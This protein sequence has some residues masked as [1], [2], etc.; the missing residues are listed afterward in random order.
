MKSILKKSVLALVLVVFSL[1]FTSCQKDSD[2]QEGSKNKIDISNNSN[3]SKDGIPDDKG[4]NNGGNNNGGNN[5]GGNNNGGNNNGGNN[6]GGNSNGGNNNQTQTPTISLAQKM[7][8]VNNIIGDDHTIYV[9]PYIDKYN[10]I[11]YR[12]YNI[13]YNK[14]RGFVKGNVSHALY[15]FGKLTKYKYRNYFLMFVTNK[16]TY[17]NA[18]EDRGI[19]DINDS[20]D[21]HRDT[22]L[23]VFMK[24]DTKRPVKIISL[25]DSEL[26]SELN[27][28]Y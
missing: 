26:D 18:F 2:K 6:N 19:F 9:Y 25:S 5:N 1:T 8:E 16:N 13:V 20:K 21:K 15:K 14:K 28:E 11:F 24:I 12:E 23:E 17:L 4:N 7:E 10:G 22:I 3:D 27:S